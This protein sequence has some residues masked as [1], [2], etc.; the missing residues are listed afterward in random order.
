MDEAVDGGGVVLLEEK[1]VEG[2]KEGHDAHEQDDDKTDLLMT[3]LRRE[4]PVSVGIS[5]NWQRYD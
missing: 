2:T 5:I 1:V 4:G 3:V